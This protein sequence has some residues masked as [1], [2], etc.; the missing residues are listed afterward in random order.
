MAINK[1]EATL[2]NVL[3]KAIISRGFVEDYDQE[4]I[5]IEI[6]RDKTHGDYSTNSF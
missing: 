6:P 4:N 3:K 2:K 1:I 5:I